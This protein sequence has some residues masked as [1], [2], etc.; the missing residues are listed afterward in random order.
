VSTWRYPHTSSTDKAQCQELQCAAYPCVSTSS[1][2][3]SFC[4]AV[5]PVGPSVVMIRCRWKQW[6]G[7][8]CVLAAILFQARPCTST[9]RNSSAS[10]SALHDLRNLNAYTLRNLIFIHEY[11]YITMK[12]VTPSALH[13]SQTSPVLLEE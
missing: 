6:F 3:S 10:S 7:G 4:G 1:R 11:I 8:R 9:C 12:C 2:S 5:Q 13:S